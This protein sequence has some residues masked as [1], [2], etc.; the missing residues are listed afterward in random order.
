MAEILSYQENI[1]DISFI[2]NTTMNELM[3]GMLNDFRDKYKE[4]TG[5]EVILSQADPNRLILYTCA[6]QI[7]QGFQYIDR[8]GK[9]NFLKYS[10]GAFLDNLA[11]LRGIK[12]KEAVAAKTTIRFTLSEARNFIV[13]VQEGSRVTSGEVYFRTISYAEIA[14]GE[15]YVDVV[16]ECVELGEKGNAYKIGEIDKIVDPLAYI[17]DV[18]N[19]TES[20]GGADI[21][22]DTQLAERIYLAP[23]HYSVAG[24]EDAYIYWVKYFNANIGDVRVYSPSPAV[25]NVMFVMENGELPNAGLIEQVEKFLQNEEIRPLTDK[26]EV[27]TPVQV[28]FNLEVKYWIKESD[29]AKA[30][31]IQMAVNKAIEMYIVWQQRNIGRDINPSQLNRYIMEAGAKRSEIT[32]PSHTVI[33]ETGVGRLEQQSISYGGI[34]DD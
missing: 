17:G 1:P 3:Q 29:R 34:E 33:G 24:P 20:A 31:N 11:L 12:R 2:D 16:A 7:Y 5:K 23:S 13:K 30:S 21:E 4:I 26:V 14:A 27:M 6:L 15:T 10:Y 22:T 28:P 25:V 18:S 32:S 9:Q 8:A 19:I